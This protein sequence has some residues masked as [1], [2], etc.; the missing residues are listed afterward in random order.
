MSRT[1]S[2]RCLFMS[3]T[4]AI[5]D[6]SASCPIQTVKPMPNGSMRLRASLEGPSRDQNG[7]Q[8]NAQHNGSNVHGGIAKSESEKDGFNDLDDQPCCHHVGGAPAE[9]IPAIQ[10]PEQGPDG[11]CSPLPRKSVINGPGF[12]NYRSRLRTAIGRTRN[13]ALRD[14]ASSLIPLSQQKRSLAWRMG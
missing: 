11:F 10:L 1:C 2:S 6:K 4:A 12:A 8:A 9:H 13:S 14:F 7:D 5:T 3:S